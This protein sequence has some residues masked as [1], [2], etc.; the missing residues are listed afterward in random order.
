MT[1]GEGAVDEEGGGERV[2]VPHTMLQKTKKDQA[3]TQEAPCHQ[4]PHRR[5]P[6]S[7]AGG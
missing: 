7:L 3:C 1:G 5:H 6:L 4:Q 2:E